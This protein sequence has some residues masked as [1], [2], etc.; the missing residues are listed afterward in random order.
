[1]NN[2][3][4]LQIN[5]LVIIGKFVQAR[6]HWSRIIVLAAANN[7][8]QPISVLSCEISSSP[9]LRTWIKS[10]FNRLLIFRSQKNEP[11]C[12]N[13]HWGIKFWWVDWRELPLS[14]KRGELLADKFT[15]KLV[16]HG[17]V[18]I[19]KWKKNTTHSY[20]STE[21]KTGPFHWRVCI[22]WY[23]PPSRGQDVHQIYP[24]FWR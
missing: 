9:N 6:N 7:S 2:R 4:L 15:F 18:D 17:P 19:E 20:I 16:E 11:S 22:Y 21:K 1:M 5:E 23:I 13:F 24:Y 14:Q 10:K 8:R 3:H 12:D